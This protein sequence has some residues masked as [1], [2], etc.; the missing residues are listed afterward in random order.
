[1]RPVGRLLAGFAT[2]AFARCPGVSQEADGLTVYSGLTAADRLA[3]Y[4]KLLPKSHPIRAVKEMYRVLVAVF[5]SSTGQRMTHAIV[6]GG[7][8]PLGLNGATRVIHP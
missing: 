7:V 5:D 8:S 4:I 1:M 6:E 2:A 3:E